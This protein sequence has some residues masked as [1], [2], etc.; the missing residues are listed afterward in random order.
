[1]GGLACAVVD[2]LSGHVGGEVHVVEPEGHDYE[3]LVEYTVGELHAPCGEFGGLE[4]YH[5]HVGLIAGG[6]AAYCVLEVKGFG[7]AACGEI[8]ALYGVEAFL[9]EHGHLVGLVELTRDREV[10]ASAHVGAH[11]H[12][13]GTARLLSFPVFELA[14]AQEEVGTRAVGH[15]ALTLVEHLPFLLAHYAAVGHHGAAPYKAE[16]PVDLGI[17]WLVGG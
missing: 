14:V 17:V 7:S 12:A 8:E 13:H 10:C 4:V 3:K 2:F 11:T 9:P 15:A 16:V 1:M 5:C 6:K